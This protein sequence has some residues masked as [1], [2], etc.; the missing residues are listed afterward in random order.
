LTIIDKS[1]EYI[2]NTEDI[3][4]GDYSG[5]ALGQI[6]THNARLIA[7]DYH[8]FRGSTHAEIGMSNTTSWRTTPI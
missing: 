6:Y 1:N 2:F 5:G 7:A 8:N 4:D 3:L